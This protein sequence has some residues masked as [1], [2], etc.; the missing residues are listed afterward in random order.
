MAH[1]HARI[2]LPSPSPR[3]AGIAAAALILAC[4][5]GC[6]RD[7][8]ETRLVHAA[9]TGLQASTGGGAAPAPP[10][11]QADVFQKVVSGVQ[12]VAQGQSDEKAAASLLMSQAQGGLGD[13]PMARTMELERDAGSLIRQGYAKLS[14]WSLH[15][16]NAASAAAYDPSAQL[17]ELAAG[18]TKAAADAERLTGTR[19][20]VDREVADLNAK[21]KAKGTAADAEMAKYTDLAARAQKGSAT[22]GLRLM[23]QARDI[24]RRAD[25][26]RKEAG[27]FEAQAAKVAPRL[28]ELDVEIAR[29]KAH[30]TDI[31]AAEARLADRKSAAAKEA[32]EA[33][34]AATVAA[35]DL[36]KL[37]ADITDLRSKGLAEAYTKAETQYT[38]A[39]RSGQDASKGLGGAGSVS[40][41]IA[42]QMVGDVQFA[43]ARGSAAYAQLLDAVARSATLPHASD[44]AAKAKAVHEEQ[45]TAAK[46]ASEAYGRAKSS[47]SSARGSPEVR[48][49]IEKLGEKLEAL[50]QVAS[51]EATDMDAALAK[52]RAAN[53]APA[54]AAKPAEQAPAPEAVAAAPAAGDDA[55]IRALFSQSIKAMTEGGDIAALYHT[56]SPDVAEAIRASTGIVTAMFALDSALW[57]KFDTGLVAALEGNPMGDAL[58]QSLNGMGVSDLADLKT[59]NGDKLTDIKIDGDKATAT[60][61]GSPAPAEFVKADGQWKLHNSQLEAMAGQITAALPMLKA[62]A[63]CFQQLAGDV[64]GGQFQ[65]ANDFKSQFM[66]RLQK[67]LMTKMQAGG[68]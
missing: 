24:K 61:P 2:A 20:Q 3:R 25:A 51:G 23:E 65:S 5:A 47:F 50:S 62:Q 9:A 46:A 1:Q 4:A 38:T 39:A 18:K 34:S 33:D 37:V 13:Q 21:A 22:D 10:K 60:A 31:T 26:L 15:R 66:T 48:E 52:I 7:S 30:Q 53:G 57:A 14:A 41:G 28:G 44:Y 63:G 58:K 56:S 40:A 12:S 29:L 11:A 59:L 32:A 43:K 8:A 19:S 67:C 36:D 35:N 68:G 64:K 54:E 6:D 49:R 45:Q 17:A 16:A 55:A 27:D 42:H